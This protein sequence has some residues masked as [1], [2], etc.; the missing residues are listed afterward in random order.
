MLKRKEEPDLFGQSFC[1][2][3]ELAITSPPYYDTE[4]YSDEETNSCNRYKSFESW[5]EGFYKPMIDKNMKAIKSW[6]EG[7]RLIICIGSRRY[8]LNKILMEHCEKNNYTAKKL[9]HF[10]L[11]GGTGGMRNIDKEG[12]TFY[13]ITKDYLGRK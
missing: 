2:E 8:P 9:W 3:I 4:I 10:R 13:M 11:T 5:T 7:G 6:Q 1:W 12:E